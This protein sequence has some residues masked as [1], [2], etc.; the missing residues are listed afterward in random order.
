MYRS[1]EIVNITYIFYKIG[2][3]IKEN[4]EIMFGDKD[5]KKNT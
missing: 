1:Q 4:S 5:S 2:K 3:I